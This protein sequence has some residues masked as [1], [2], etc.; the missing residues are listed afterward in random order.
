MTISFLKFVTFHGKKIWKPNDPVILYPNLCYNEV[1]CIGTA[2]N[3][4]RCFHFLMNGQSS[5]IMHVSVAFSEFH[6]CSLKTAIRL[7]FVMFHLQPTI[8]M[9]ASFIN[10][11]I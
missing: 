2:L 4:E 7:V 1:C 5:V 11:P 8:E 6:T 3:L 10:N 9:A